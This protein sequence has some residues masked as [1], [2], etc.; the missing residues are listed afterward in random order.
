MPACSENKKEVPYTSTCIHKSEE[1]SLKERIQHLLISQKCAD[2]GAPGVVQTERS[3][4][5]LH[6]TCL[7]LAVLLNARAKG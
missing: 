7:A 2:Q 5:N 3:V 6:E 4:C 1:S